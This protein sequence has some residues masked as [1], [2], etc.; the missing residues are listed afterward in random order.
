MA[1]RKKNHFDR[2]NKPGSLN[3]YR[4]LLLGAWTLLL[5]SS[6]G[7]NVWSTYNGMND[8]AAVQARAIA[9][10]DIIYR[11]WVSSLGGVYVSRSAGVL[12]NPYL[13][14]NP[15]RDLK[16][17]GVEL[18]LVNPEY[19]SRMVDRF[20]QDSL[21]ISIRMTSLDVINPQ[22]TPDQWE[23][24]ALRSIYRDGKEVSSIT[25][26]GESTY[27]RAMFPLASEQWCQGCHPGSA[28]F[29]SG[30]ISGGLSVRIPLAAYH[31]QAVEDILNH[32][33]THLL[34]WLVGLA[35]LQF[36]YSNLLRADR[37]RKLSELRTQ[38]ARDAAVAANQAKSQFLAHMS[39]EIRTP[40][41]AVIGM[42]QLVLESDLD[43]RQR[44]SMQMVKTS[45]DHLLKV[46][47]DILDFSK[48]EAGFLQLETIPFNLQDNLHPV[49]GGLALSAHQKGLEF[50]CQIAPEVPGQLVGDPLR[51]RQ[52]LVNL[53][54]NAI[55]F[56]RQGEVVVSISL[57]PTH[58][59]DSGEATLL[60]SVRDTG[61]GI[62]E[63]QIPRLFESFNQGDSSTTRRFGGTGLGLT[64][65]RQLVELQRGR[66]Q[67]VSA[68]G[69]G[70]CFTVEIPF[71]CQLPGAEQAGIPADLSGKRILL[72]DNNASVRASVNSCLGRLGL[73]VMSADTFL[74]ASDILS[75]DEHM[76]FDLLLID[77]DLGDKG[78]FDLVRSC[79]KR[80]PE[81]C[82]IVMLLQPHLA[83]EE[84]RICTELGVRHLIK[85]CWGEHC[86]AEIMAI[87]RHQVCP[88]RGK[89]PPTTSL[90]KPLPDTGPSHA[91]VLVVEDNYFN[92]KVVLS[93]LERRGIV[94]RVAENGQQAVEMAAG[95]DIDLIFMD[96]QMPVLDGL[97]ATRQI[98]AAQI[99][100]GPKIV[101][102]TAH[103]QE[104]DRT[105]CLDAGMD[106]YLSKP[107]D[108]EEFYACLGRILP[109]CP[110]SATVAREELLLR[111][112]SEEFLQDYPEDMQRLQRAL[113][114]RDAATIYSLAHQL[115]SVVGFLRMEQAYGMFRDLEA[116][117]K[118]GDFDLATKLVALLV[119]ELEEFRRCHEI[120]SL[121]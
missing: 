3:A 32:G 58:N 64:I 94:P 57:A 25:G 4:N 59:P 52:V 101:G 50:V 22:N 99:G 38:R 37:A 45:A 51:L 72:V 21:G 69:E 23:V 1:S 9:D 12:P 92:Q 80:L 10:Q 116:A 110:T 103:A 79:R 70:S 81:H 61:V 33:I 91:K 65:V 102:L 6:L 73:E 62:A 29:S 75:A 24:E 7:W 40:M 17:D 66:V 55:K 109:Q 36:G 85:P 11:R 27:L 89:I 49:L 56:T 121:A 13:S 19:M 88:E 44:E 2:W 74:A 90:S 42:S 105:R 119:A 5:A 76:G 46:I 63:E 100:R 47:N 14:D 39:H 60:F 30:T 86:L 115:K 106:D 84:V 31:R 98:R 78:G 93:L 54:N 71:Q 96:I 41:N 83:H 43:S 107:I 118:Q 97:E 34:I 16:I 104:A 114:D 113:V 112:M 28:E 26:L 8:L 20:Q 117:G 67:V 53:V 120:H 108:A 95:D 18:T 82:Q 87:L 48:I 68:V 35:A 77:D 15:L 111:R